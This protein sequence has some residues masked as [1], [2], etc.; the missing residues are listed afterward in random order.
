MTSRERVNR[1]QMKYLRELLKELATNK[2][3]KDKMIILG[4]D[5]NSYQRHI[6]EEV[7]N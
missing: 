3:Y 5:L 6:F 1:E 7:K 4:G 2:N